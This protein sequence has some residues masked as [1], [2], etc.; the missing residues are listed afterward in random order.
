MSDMRGDD[1]ML[2]NR[3]R[4]KR[5]RTEFPYGWDADDLVSRRRLLQWAV[6]AS[7]AL[8]AATGMLAVLAQVKDRR[9][10]EEREIIAAGE[11]APGGV[12]YFD[13]PGEEDLA[14]LLHLDTGDFV[15]YSGKCTHLSCAVYW[16]AGRGELVCPCHE[17][18]FDPRTGE[19]IAGPPSRPLPRIILREEGGMLYAVEEVPL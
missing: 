13:F 11:L 3:E 14:I 9:R 2:S 7:G 15:A 8:F 1:R 5:W 10:G 12:H 18:V 17:G 4:E 6:W 16:D 19:V